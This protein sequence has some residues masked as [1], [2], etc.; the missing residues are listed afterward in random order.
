MTHWSTPR[1]TGGR[2]NVGDRINVAVDARCG[3]GE[4]ITA[5]MPP[6]NSAG[7]RL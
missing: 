5:S 4:P 3:T 7:E 6:D 1:G 2:R